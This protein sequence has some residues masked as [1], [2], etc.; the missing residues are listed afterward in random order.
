MLATRTVPLY[1]AFDVDGVLADMD[2]EL[3]RQAEIL[4]GEMITH[5]LQERARIPDQAPAG[6]A[7]DQ[8][9]VEA[10]SQANAAASLDDTLAL[11]QLNMTAR[12]RRKLWRHVENIENVWETLKELEPGLVR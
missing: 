3:V 5:R 2:S 8:A 10:G 11:V 12:K 7:A 6:V 1:V 4:F 9:S